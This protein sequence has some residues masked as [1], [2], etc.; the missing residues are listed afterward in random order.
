MKSAVEFIIEELYKLA[1]LSDH[2]DKSEFIKARTIIYEKAKA[3]EKDQLG[4]LYLT[5]LLNTPDITKFDFEEW[6]NQNT[7]K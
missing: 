4:A 2:L 5:L 6:Y 3:R 1:V 7:K